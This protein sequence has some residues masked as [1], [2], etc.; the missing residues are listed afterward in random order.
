MVAKA[1]G[2]THRH[3]LDESFGVD[4]QS[5]RHHEPKDAARLIEC[6]SAHL[7]VGASSMLFLRPPMGVTEPGVARTDSSPL[8]LEVAEAMRVVG[9]SMENLC[10]EYGEGCSK[11]I[12][13]IV[14][15]GVR[16]AGGYSLQHVLLKDAAGVMRISS[17]PRAAGES[18]AHFVSAGDGGP[19]AARTERL[20]VG[21]MEGSSLFHRNSDDDCNSF[22][23]LGVAV[24][25]ATGGPCKLLRRASLLAAADAGCRR[26]LF[27]A[28]GDDKTSSKCFDSA[29]AGL[30]EGEA[31][32]PVFPRGVA[33]AAFS[34]RAQDP[35]ERGGSEVG[36]ETAS[37]KGA[38]RRDAGDFQ[39]SCCCGE[40]EAAPEGGAAPDAR[41]ARCGSPL[42]WSTG[43]FTRPAL[44]TGLL[45]RRRLFHGSN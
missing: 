19:T 25:V 3:K 29:L 5:S 7:G 6:S 21:R 10:V 39:R 13:D 14:D 15:D 18:S 43:A 41:A 26:P 42:R 31:P 17:A 27:D 16:P 24:A 12:H 45:A 23:A 37:V 36:S 2:S 4:G 30:E 9:V 44:V 28:K 20:A 11:D 40:G 33:A 35:G 8:P 1:G 32:L 22:D 38:G 34:R